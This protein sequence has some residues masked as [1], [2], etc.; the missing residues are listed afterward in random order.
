LK[1][2]GGLRAGGP[3]ESAFSPPV[4]AYGS[5][6]TAAAGIIG[7]VDAALAYAHFFSVVALAA[8]L[9]LA[10]SRCGDDVEP[11]DVILLA[12][13]D[14]AS[15]TALASCILTG[16]ARAWA[17]STAPVFYTANPVFWQGLA[18]L[19]AIAIVHTVPG[20]QIRS[21]RRALARGSGRV[22]SGVE[23]VRVRRVIAFELVLLAAA[24]V[25]GVLAGR[26]VGLPVRPSGD[27]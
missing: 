18:L 3:S 19:T 13:I 20:R 2:A 17:G 24:A 11:R 1:Q 26:G 7:P 27:V 16:S 8:L 12:R 5:R 10:Y 21:W 9:A 15:V 25:A 22:L 6:D 4:V 23:L 14:L